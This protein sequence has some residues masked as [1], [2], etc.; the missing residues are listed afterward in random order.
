[1]A[2][3]NCPDCNHDVSTKALSC[4][5]CGCPRPPEGWTAGQT[6]RAPLRPSLTDK[7][8]EAVK[9][10]EDSVEDGFSRTTRSVLSAARTGK[11]SV[12]GWIVIGIIAAVVLIVIVRLPSMSDHTGAVP[13]TSEPVRAPGGSGASSSPAQPASSGAAGSASAAPSTA[14][15]PTTGDYPDAALQNL[16]AATKQAFATFV[17][18]RSE[19]AGIVNDNR[20]S[21]APLLS[22]AR[23]EFIASAVQPWYDNESDVRYEWNRAIDGLTVPRSDGG[24]YEGPRADRAKLLSDVDVTLS[25][26]INLLYT[27]VSSTVAL[28]NTEGNGFDFK[29]ADLQEQ[30]ARAKYAG[31]D[32]RKINEQTDEVFNEQMTRPSRLSLCR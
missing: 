20:A 1:M 30:L 12:V 6:T 11:R 5:Y 13:A 9:M 26:G 22:R 14:A 16:E 17:Q 15:A 7:M 4:P 28:C 27:A 24:Y 31:R 29:A 10:I 2:L 18:M 3:V 32:T 8:L 21:T 25:V 23:S 19:A